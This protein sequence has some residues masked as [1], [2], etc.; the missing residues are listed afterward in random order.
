VYTP[1]LHST[2]H[3]SNFKLTLQ[4]ILY[5]LLDRF[6]LLTEEMIFDTWIDLRKEVIT[7]W[8]STQC[9]KFI[10]FNFD[11]FTTG[12]KEAWIDFTVFI[13][14]MLI[15]FHSFIICYMD[16]KHIHCAA[17]YPSLVNAWWWLQRELSHTQIV[18]W[19]YTSGN[20][21]QPIFR[22]DTSLPS[23][24]RMISNNTL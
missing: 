14:A 24:W 20:L 3:N 23:G 11:C 16:E 10:K 6:R 17:H 7:S 1:T 12:Y 8:L 19:P 22:S 21:W 2:K 13:L 5:D 18:P 15:Q 9:C 4:N